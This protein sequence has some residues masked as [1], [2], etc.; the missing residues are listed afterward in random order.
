[1]SACGSLTVDPTATMQGCCKPGPRSSHADIW[2]ETTR[3]SSLW[4]KVHANSPTSL[5]KARCAALFV[6]R[7]SSV[8][9]WYQPPVRL[10]QGMGQTGQSNN[11]SSSFQAKHPWTWPP[12]LPASTA[13]YMPGCVDDGD[14]DSGDGGSDKEDGGGGS[15]AVVMLVVVMGPI[16]CPSSL[17]Q[18]LIQAEQ[19]R[20]ASALQTQF[21]QKE[22]EEAI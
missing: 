3:L 5:Q 16:L 11:D 9:Y 14:S 4:H 20:T 18:G 22:P 6:A 12:R 8:M 19:C 13:A 10:S 17:A 7:L 15:L 2:A 1:M 21:Q